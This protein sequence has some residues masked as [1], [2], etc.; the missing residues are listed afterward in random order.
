MLFAGIG[1]QNSAGGGPGVLVRG[2]VRVRV[3]AVAD[4]TIRLHI[5]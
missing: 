1:G 3:E 4:G 5:G 2:L